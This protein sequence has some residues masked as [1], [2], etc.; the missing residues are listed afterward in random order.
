MKHVGLDVHQVET[1]VVW[2]DAE[3]G[4]VSRA[5]SVP[6]PAVPEHLQ[7][8]GECLR[9]V[10]ESGLHSKFLA[11]QLVSCG[12]AV[13]VLDARKVA[14]LM[15]AYK[16]TK[17]DRLDARALARMSFDNALS[18]LRVWV[19]DDHTEELRALTRTREKL[20]EQTTALRNEWRAQ[21]V[22]FGLVCPADDVLSQKA[23][24]WLAEHF[25]RL[26]SWAQFCWQRLRESLISLREQIKLLDREIER[27]AAQDPAC[28]KLRSLPGC[29]ALLAVTIVAELG[30]VARF[31][32][33]R[34][35]CSYAGLTPTVRQSGERSYTGRIA[36]RGNPHLRR[37]L[38]LLAQ[39]FAWQKDL[40][41]T[42]L[43]KR[44]YRTLHKHGPNAAKV[45]LARGL[46]RVIVAMLRADQA[47]AP[48]QRL[49]A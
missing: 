11:R 12:F 48:P 19:A 26:P 6:T 17:T 3:T 27:Q 14:A 18:T 34:Q 13:W 42:T 15:P 16:T 44:Y 39:H 31:G 33:L 49:A 41:E 1:T 38:V 32:N 45:A 4:E 7:G 8:L 21:G 37:A 40:G 43:K 28:Q 20:V 46:C 10:M 2:I 5:C 35:V 30:D 9:V 47:F 29:G 36:R 23:E 24:R 25:D 22:A